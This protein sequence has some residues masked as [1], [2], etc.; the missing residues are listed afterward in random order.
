MWYE[1]LI[2]IAGLALAVGY[3]AWMFLRSF[4][5]RGSCCGS[6]CASDRAESD[7]RPRVTPLVELKPPP[8]NHSD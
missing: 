8:A 4:R 2:I 7:R 5:A 1:Y 6:S 3:V